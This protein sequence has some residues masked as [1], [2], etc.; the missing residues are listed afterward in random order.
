MNSNFQF[1][2]KNWP[3]LYALGQLAEKYLYVDPNSCIVKIGM[4]MESILIKIFE[5]E[6]IPVPNITTSFNLIKILKEEDVLPKNVNYSLYQIRKTRNLAVHSNLD[7][8][9]DALRVLKIIFN[10]C[11]W[12]MVVYGDWKY[13]SKPFVLPEEN[14]EEDHIQISNLEE[15]FNL[16]EENKG[17][18]KSVMSDINA[19]RRGEISREASDEIVQLDLESQ[20][21]MNN[22]KVIFD[23][24]VIPVINYSMIQNGVDIISDF[25]LI[26]RTEEKYENLFVEIRSIPEF[27]APYTKKIDLLEGKNIDSDFDNELYV[28]VDLEIDKQFMASLEEEQ[29]GNISI[30]IFSGKTELNNE[31]FDISLLTYNQWQ[32]LNIYPECLSSF[33]IP[34]SSYVEMINTRAAIIL[35]EWDKNL[36]LDA[37]KS[38]EKNRVRL[39]AAAIYDAIQE[40]KLNCAKV[41]G[42]FD[43]E[44]KICLFEHKNINDISVTTLDI[45]ILYAACLEF[46][47]IN[48]MLILNKDK[49]YVGYW[50]QDITLPQVLTD[51]ISILTKKIADGVN[52]LRVVDSS[53]LFSHIKSTYENAEKKGEALLSSE[54]FQC[55]LDIKAARLNNYE[56][57]SDDGLMNSE[58]DNQDEIDVQTDSLVSAPALL[59]Q[60]DN[61]DSYENVGENT[62]YTKQEQWERKL[63]NL[64]GRNRL[65]NTHLSARTIP[66]YCDSLID[67]EKELSKDKSFRILPKVESIKKESNSKNFECYTQLDDSA[68]FIHSEFKSYRLHTSYTEGELEG[69]TKKLYREAR[70]SLEEN[71]ANTLYLA[72]GFLK[73]YEDK[74]QDS[75]HY[76]P[77]VLYPVEITKKTSSFEYEMCSRNEDVQINV[78]LVEKLKRDFDL[79]I[80]GLDA[81]LDDKSEIE[82]QK[83]FT[84]FRNVIMHQKYWTVVETA[85]LGIFSFSQF[86]MW[87]DMHQRFDVLSENPIIQSLIN[88]KL[89]PELLNTSEE[90][91]K[92]FL[93]IS[94][95]E[96]QMIALEEAEKGNS[97]I[98]HGPPGTGKSQTI[99]AIIANALGNGKKVLFV[100]SN[101]S[102]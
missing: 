63:L 7:S 15:K 52:E 31:I 91:D 88:Q 28:N 49:A 33:I 80:P 75:P 66:F 69:N 51:D 30:K 11:N 72:L 81:I 42:S 25:K 19:Q 27:F 83:I 101:L 55:I 17:L 4:M 96:S 92:T 45:S 79:E 48:P 60:L 38:T 21:L 41:E 70:M 67:L 68:S 12:F 18:N 56:S 40:Q 43:R 99:T 26:N 87:N 64:D 22:E 35:N 57:I 97:F 93:P 85:C 54:D 89:S 9:D 58:V 44:Q 23:A 50:L 100:A 2:E 61:N 53:A 62:Q 14:A 82:L 29:T 10:L 46:A 32:G 37:Y 65:I 20:A 95:D 3:D 36:E 13:E 5:Y 98:L 74:K 47:G 34:N 59:Q 39:Q 71:G 8:K 84:L 76:A 73:W 90:K 94:L 77:I 1:C 86:V 78:T 24:D 6:K 102:N 16:L